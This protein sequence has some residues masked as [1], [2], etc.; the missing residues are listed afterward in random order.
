MK[1][2]TDK[3]LEPLLALLLAAMTLNV[4]WQVFSRYVLGSPS[5]FT[6]ELSRYLL[7][8]LGML[9]GAYASGQRMHLSIELLPARLS[10][11]AG[12]LASLMLMLFAGAAL[13]A[14]GGWLALLTF[15]KGQASAALGLPLGYVY[16]V[17]PLSGLLT[18]WYEL[19]H[20]LRP[21]ERAS[22]P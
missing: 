20:L 15:S 22:Q 21:A 16:L 9:G 4:C 3:L 1:R 12:R 19:L 7:I 14:G 2:R 6:E 11:G 13:V 8:W 18:L 5:S 17:L 10:A